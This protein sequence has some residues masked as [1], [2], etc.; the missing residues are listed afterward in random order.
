[1]ELEARRRELYLRHGR[2]AHAA[3]YP[4][5]R[6][7]PRRGHGHAHRALS[8]GTT[9]ATY[10]RYSALAVLPRD[11]GDMPEIERCCRAVRGAVRRAHQ[12]YRRR[13]AA[14]VLALR[15]ASCSSPAAGADVLDG[16]VYA[17][18]ITSARLRRK[19]SAG[20]AAR[21]GLCLS[22]AQP[23]PARRGLRAG[24]R[25]ARPRAGARTPDDAAE[26]GILHD[27]TKETQHG[28]AVDIGGKIWYSVR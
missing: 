5:A 7:S 2:R 3:E 22:Q 11:E 18:I 25:V 15:C 16:E 8:A 14:H 17:R 24:G 27:I 21:A 9:S 23:R 1:M 19:A 12:G 28:R 26:A 20:L 4:G 10:S 13:A 6:D